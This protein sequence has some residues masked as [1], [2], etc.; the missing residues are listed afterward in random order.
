MKVPLKIPFWENDRTGGPLLKG[1]SIK[2]IKEYTAYSIRLTGEYI[3]ILQQSHEVPN[4]KTHTVRLVQ[5]EF[6][7]GDIT[8]TFHGLVYIAV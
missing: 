8:F 5:I 6:S 1:E 3:P 4:L 2:E 7:I